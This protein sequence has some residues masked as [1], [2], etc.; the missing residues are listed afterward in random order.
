MNRLIWI[1]GL[2]CAVSAASLC[3]CQREKRNASP[4]DAR[5]PTIKTEAEL[6][7]DREA[8]IE[9]G[10]VVPTKS[11]VLAEAHRPDRPRRVLPTPIRP[12][13][14]AIEADILL[15]NEAVVTAAEVLYPIHEQVEKLRQTRT[16]AGFAEAVRALARRQTQQR[17]GTLLVYAEAIGEL[18]DEQLARLAAVVDNELENVTAH[19]FGGSAARRDAHLAEHGLTLER[20]RAGLERGM[21]VRQ[22]TREKLMP[23]V[24][25]PRTE[26]LSF[27]RQNMARY[28]A[29]ETRELLMIELPFEKFLPEGRAWSGASPTVRAQAKLKAMRRARAAEEALR[30]RSFEDVAREYSR[31][32]HAEQGGSWGMIGKPLQ[33]PYDAV[34]GLIFEYS[35][36]Q[37]SAPIETESGWYI[38]KCGRIQP[39]EER[40]FAEAQD[41]IREELMD[42]RFARLSTDYVL[43]LAENATMSSLDSFLAAVLRRARENT[44]GATAG[45]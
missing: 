42:R 3:G 9:A 25:I 29:P 19:E 33:S 18:E 16:E 27:Y 36:G 12:S 4:P 31:G 40:S 37:A 30:E 15:V 45:P 5:R 43:R 28:S 26:L 21:V 22:Y 8:R 24:Q 38:V 14:G 6:A 11:P 34:S 7:A 2:L 13:P 44:R 35:A 1:G 41:E 17:I 20:Y 10:E 23:Q 32:L 39:A